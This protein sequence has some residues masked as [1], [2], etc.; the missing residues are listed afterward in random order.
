MVSPGAAV[1]EWIVLERSAKS[2]R[3]AYWLSWIGLDWRGWARTVGYCHATSC[4]GES[5][6]ERHGL[7]SPFR[8]WIV[9]A[10]SVSARLG[11]RGTARTVMDRRGLF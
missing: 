2:L 7:S 5:V 6:V 4:C 8:E 10:S 1:T 3:G 11:S 9:T